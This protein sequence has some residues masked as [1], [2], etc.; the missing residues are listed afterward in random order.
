MRKYYHFHLNVHQQTPWT[1]TQQVAHNS[2]TPVMV[3]TPMSASARKRNAKTAALVYS[4]SSQVKYS[5]NAAPS[6]AV[7]TRP[8]AQQTKALAHHKHRLASWV[9]GRPLAGTASRM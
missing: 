8:Q 4:S 5:Q 2:L 6:R 3:G 7:Q 1:Q 9:Q